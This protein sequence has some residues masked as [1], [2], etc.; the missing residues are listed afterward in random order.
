MD[1]LCEDL[2]TMRNRRVTDC[3]AVCAQ[4]FDH[5]VV[6]WGAMHMPGIESTLLEQGAT[7]E[8]RKR[9]L[10]LG[11]RPEEKHTPASEEAEPEKDSK[12]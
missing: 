5:I 1:V 8:S 12:L 4:T 11:W 7:V 6:P 3:I 2:L 9:V 10:V